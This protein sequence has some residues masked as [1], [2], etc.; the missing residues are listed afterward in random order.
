MCWLEWVAHKQ[1]VYVQFIRM[2]NLRFK[3]QNCMI[4]L[5]SK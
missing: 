4:W 3:V 1:S 2:W 5:K